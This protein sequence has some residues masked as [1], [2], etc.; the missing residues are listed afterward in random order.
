MIFDLFDRKAFR[1]DFQFSYNSKF[2]WILADLVCHKTLC[3]QPT[4][5]TDFIFRFNYYDP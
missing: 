1:I 4:L 5:E 2:L 3:E